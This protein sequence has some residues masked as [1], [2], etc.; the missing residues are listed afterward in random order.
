MFSK[1][2]TSFA[3]QLFIVL[4]G[5]AIVSA[6][7]MRA[8]TKPVVANQLTGTEWELK[9]LSNYEAAAPIERAPTLSFSEN[10]ISGFN[11]CNR[12]F[13]NYAAG[14]DGS[15]ALGQVGSTKMACRGQA[16]NLEKNVNQALTITQLFALSR[17]A[18]NLMDGERNVLMALTPKVTK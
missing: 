7:S 13:A 12:I 6:C 8:E 17:D 10:R 9:K 18:L 14:Q 16:G 11:G 4:M 15:I 1:I 2:I 3:G 5:L